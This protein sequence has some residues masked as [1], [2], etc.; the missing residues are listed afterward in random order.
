MK[1]Y[2]LDWALYPRRIGIYLAEKGIENIERIAF[3]ATDEGLGFKLKALSPLGT[4]PMLETESG[5]HI[6]S[7][8]AIL[9]YLEECFPEP[10][11]I[12]RTPEERALTRELVSVA[13]E[14]ALQLGIWCHK[15]SPVFAGAEEQSA[16]AARFASQ[17]YRRQLDRLDRLLAETGGPF[18]TGDKVSLADCVAMATLEF[19]EGAYGVPLPQEFEW[20]SHWYARF[21]ERPSASCPPYPPA[22]L[23]QAYGLPQHS[24]CWPV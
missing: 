16:D 13:D 17:S 7:S 15:G 19:A 1:L 18:L 5:C 23:D 20:L 22:F 14:A 6:R 9:E 8:I 21:K 3:D 11:M 10:D 12:G 2:E 24:Q 4:V